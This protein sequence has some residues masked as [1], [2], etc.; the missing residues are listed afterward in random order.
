MSECPKHKNLLFKP[1][2]LYIIQNLCGMC[3]YNYNIC[4]YACTHVCM[5][6]SLGFLWGKSKTNDI[7]NFKLTI[8]TCLWG[9]VQDKTND[10]NHRL[11]DFCN[12][13]LN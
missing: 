9:K 10:L 4:V 5:G 13:C 8:V 3:I 6:L 12:L 7:K 11:C 1:V 2:A